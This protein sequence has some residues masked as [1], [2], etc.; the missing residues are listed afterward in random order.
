[1]S[2]FCS[3]EHP[4]CLGRRRGADVDSC[5]PLTVK[6]HDKRALPNKR[7][8]KSSHG[9]T[10]CM[11]RHRVGDDVH[12]LGRQM[13]IETTSLELRWTMLSTR[14][15]RRNSVGVAKCGDDETMRAHDHLHAHASFNGHCRSCPTP[16]SLAE[17]W[18]RRWSCVCVVSWSPNSATPATFSSAQLRT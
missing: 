14:L 1:M 3:P 6:V 7:E 12:G 8:W 13:T 5:A 2:S 4:P 11:C 15:S 17:A 9:K 16:C 18:T 10:K